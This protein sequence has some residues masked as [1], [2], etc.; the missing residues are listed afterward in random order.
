MK[1]KENGTFVKGS[2]PWNKGNK[3]QSICP[4]CGKHFNKYGKSGA[5]RKSCSRK[6]S[7]ELIKIARAKQIIPKESY[8]KMG[9][10]NSQENSHQWKGEK[11]SYSGLHRWLYKYKKRPNECQHCGK[12]NKINK[13]GSNYLHWANISGK[14]KRELDDYIALCPSCHKNYDLGKIKI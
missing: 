12:E 2:K 14:Y 8:K 7:I 4:I 11:V 1:R 9:L 10:K 6:C 13:N 3:I 5:K